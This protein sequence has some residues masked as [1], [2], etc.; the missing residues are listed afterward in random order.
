MQWQTKEFNMLEKTIV[1]FILQLALNLTGYPQL[2]DDFIV[3]DVMFVTRETLVQ[4]ACERSNR[5]EIDECLTRYTKRKLVGFYDR[6]NPKIYILETL[7]KG[8]NNK[9][10]YAVG[11]ALHEFVHVLQMK[12]R[13]AD[14]PEIGSNELN[15]D[16]HEAYTIQQKFMKSNLQ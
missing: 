6:F 9:E 14:N 13:H 3:P 5:E 12:Y 2:P 7:E 4:K 10:S 8:L 16:E 1:T 11:V 15:Q